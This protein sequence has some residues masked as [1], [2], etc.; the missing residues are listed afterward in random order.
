MAALLY[1]MLSMLLCARWSDASESTRKEYEEG[2]DI[3]IMTD[4]SGSAYL[5]R[6]LRQYVERRYTVIVYNSDTVLHKTFHTSAGDAVPD[7]FLRMCDRVYGVS[8][9]S[10]TFSVLGQ[11]RQVGL[12]RTFNLLY[13]LLRDSL[14]S[15]NKTHDTHVIVAT[16]PNVNDTE[17]NHILHTHHLIDLLPSSNIALHFYINANTKH[18]TTNIGQP[19]HGVTYK[20]GSHFNKALT[21]NRLLRHNVGQTY[22]GILL[23]R[24]IHVEVHD[25]RDMILDPQLWSPLGTAFKDV[26]DRCRCGKDSFCSPLHGCYPYKDLDR[27]LPTDPPSLPQPSFG[28]SHAD[29]APNATA[30]GSGT[31]PY[32]LSITDTSSTHTAPFVDTVVKTTDTLEWEPDRPFVSHVVAGGDP[33]VLRNTVVASWPALRKWNMSYLTDNMGT[34]TLPFVKCSD[35]YLTFDPDNRAPL[36]LTVPIPYDVQNMTTREFFECVS[37]GECRYKG[38][39]YFGSVPAGLKH[40]VLPDDFLYH[41]ERDYGAGRQFVWISSPGMI[42]HG[43]FDQD[44]NIFVQ[45]VGRK[46]FTFWSPWQHDMLYVYPRVHPL[47]HKSRINF[48][49]PDHAQFPRFKYSQSV[50]VVLEPGDVLYVP[51]Y[52]WHYVETL[53]PS[54]SLSTWSHDYQVYDNMN[55][56]YGHDHKFDLIASPKGT[57]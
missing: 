24:G 15:I 44:Y 3:V 41:T 21:L 42:T 27:H 13:R 35:T 16:S 57:W 14:V 17:D 52:T 20:D 26:C 32:Q 51:P 34:D 33:V 56:I 50:Q 49:H 37:E 29:L 12:E 4:C 6:A 10:Y 39:Y 38:Y 18:L 43:H 9:N 55:A 48:Q 28:A 25:V 5:E 2:V 7:D 46:R 54:V 22:Q 45:V 11:S 1:M 47:W 23:S 30:T 31:P 40:D 19:G 8:Y 36:K 53:S